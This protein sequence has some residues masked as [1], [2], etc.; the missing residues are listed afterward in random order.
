MLPVEVVA[1]G[2]LLLDLSL[3]L[4]DV[5]LLQSAGG[6]LVLLPEYADVVTPLEPTSLRR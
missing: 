6:G 1:L 5:V 4:A 2:D 3:D